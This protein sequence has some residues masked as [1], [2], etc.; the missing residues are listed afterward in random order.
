MIIWLDKKI[1]PGFIFSW[2]K[3]CLSILFVKCNVVINNLM[4]I[5]FF[6]FHKSCGF[7]YFGRAWMT[8]IFLTLKS[9]CY[10][11]ILG[12]TFQLLGISICRFKPSN[13]RAVFNIFFVF[14]LALQ[15]YLSLFFPFYPFL[16]FFLLNFLRCYSVL[17]FFRFSLYKIWFYL[18]YVLQF[19]SSH[20]VS[21]FV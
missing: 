20:F 17:S 3:K 21:S 7:V 4:P 9:N 18:N 12:Q 1:N 11:S 2:G 8:K 15:I 19:V 14:H 13:F 16:P 10:I 5:G 6:H